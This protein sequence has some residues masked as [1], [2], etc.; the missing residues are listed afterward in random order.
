[1]VVR[2]GEH[3]L[4]R[5]EKYS[6][7]YQVQQIFIHPNYTR[8]GGFKNWVQINNAD[9]ALLKTT[10]DIHMSTFVWPVCFPPA[11]FELIGQEAIIIGW[12]KVRMMLMRVSQI[13]HYSLHLATKRSEKSD[14]SNILQK[15]RL[16]IIH[17]RNCSEWF[18]A[19]GR[20]FDISRD[21]I[22]AGFKAG[23]TDAC[24]G[25]RLV[26]SCPFTTKSSFIVVLL[27][28]RKQWRPVAHTPKVEYVEFT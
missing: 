24:Y 10:D 18:R 27:C 12:G 23:G 26:Q 28:H 6:R 11:N 22:C 1:L 2:V 17:S 14:I 9:I 5:A 7:D 8:I 21:Q 4:M 15:A 19:A 16:N 3:D 20:D 13:K 25:D